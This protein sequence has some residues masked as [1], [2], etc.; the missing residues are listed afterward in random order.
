[1]LRNKCINLEENNLQCQQTAGPAEYEVLYCRRSL[2]GKWFN[3]AYRPIFN[4]ICSF[5]YMFSVNLICSPVS[6]KHGYT[7]MCTVFDEL[8]VC[9]LINV[10]I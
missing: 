7:S 6:S 1:M 8:Y 4:H 10:Y 5:I 9:M 3:H 2:S